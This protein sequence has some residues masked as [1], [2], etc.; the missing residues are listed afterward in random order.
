M[1]D[2][3]AELRAQLYA[4]VVSFVSLVILMEDDYPNLRVTLSAFLS[5]MA[6]RSGDEQFAGAL[7]AMSE[8]LED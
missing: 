1:D 6:E 8:N 3:A 5:G 4:L 7:R 2:T